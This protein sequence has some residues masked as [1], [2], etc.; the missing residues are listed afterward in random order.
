[1]RRAVG[2]AIKAAKWRNEY[3]DKAD[4]ALKEMLDGTAKQ[5]Y[6]QS[7]E[8]AD[9]GRLHSIAGGGT[10]KSPEDTG[11]LENNADESNDKGYFDLGKGNS[12]WEDDDW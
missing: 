8:R 5:D 3:S 9:T 2:L 10:T 6:R 1:M 12:I 11:E 7:P 4:K